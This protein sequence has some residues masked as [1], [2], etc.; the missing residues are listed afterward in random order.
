MVQVHRDMYASWS[1]YTPCTYIH[2]ATTTCH[3]SIFS[4]LMTINLY[5]RSFVAILHHIFSL[6]PSHQV[7]SHFLSNLTDKW[8]EYITALLDDS[9]QEGEHCRISIGTSKQIIKLKWPN[10]AL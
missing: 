6:L 2:V 3:P 10:A 4:P 1:A 5:Y 8:R 7:Q 9:I